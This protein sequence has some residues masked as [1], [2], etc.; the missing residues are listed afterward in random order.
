MWWKQAFRF[1][2]E[3][4]KALCSEEEVTIR[5]LFAPLASPAPQAAAAS[6]EEAAT[7]FDKDSLPEPVVYGRQNTP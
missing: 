3:V 1:T 6:T 4:L 7:A 5:R 2:L